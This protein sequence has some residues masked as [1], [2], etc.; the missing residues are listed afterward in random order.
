[1]RSQNTGNNGDNHNL[2]SKEIIELPENPR[3][4]LLVMK[5]AAIADQLKRLRRE[6]LWKAIRPYKFYDWPEDQ[7]NLRQFMAKLWVANNYTM[8][9]PT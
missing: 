4:E 6:R 3:I 1:M 8:G 5:M 7:E 2:L 9:P